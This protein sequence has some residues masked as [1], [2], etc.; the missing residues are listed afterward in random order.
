MARESKIGGKMKLIAGLVM[1]GLAF[2]QQPC[3]VEITKIDTSNGF[4]A[5]LSAAVNNLGPSRGY[6]TIAFANKS[7]KIVATVRFGVG[8]LN[9]MRELSNVEM[10]TTA[11]TK[12]KPGKSSAVV[13]PNGYITAGAKA[14]SAGWVEKILFSDGTYWNDDGSRSCGNFAGLTA[15]R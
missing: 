15:P 7:E 10:V 6:F 14:K 5:H 8:Y 9:S 1:A 12:L 3:P 4:A 13:G 2:G 11:E